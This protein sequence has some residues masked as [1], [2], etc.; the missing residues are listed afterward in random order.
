MYAITKNNF[1]WCYYMEILQYFDEFFNGNYNR[2]LRIFGKNS[3]VKH[4][5][6][7]DSTTARHKKSKRMFIKNN[8]N[9]K[10]A[11]YNR[12]YGGHAYFSD[13][14]D[15]QHKNECV[16]KFNHM[17]FDFDKE[18]VVGSK[19]K[20]ITKG[21]GKENLGITDLE[22]LPL[23]EYMHGMDEIQ[24]QIQDMI[25]YE[26]ILKDSWIES[27]KVYEY[28]KQQGLKAYPCLSMS[29]GVHLRVFFNPIKVK[30][31]NRIIHNLHDN[32]VKQFNLK[33]LDVKVTGKDS[34]PSKSVERLPYTF[35]EKS[36][37][38]VVPFSF[39][40]DRL[41]DVIEKSMK[42]SSKDKLTNVEHFDLSE[43]VNADFHNGILKLDKQIDA[44]IEKENQAKEK[45]LQEKIKNGTINGNY[46][47][48]NALFKDLRILVRFVCGDEN[49]V[50]EHDRYDK[51]KCHFHQDKSPSAIVGMKNYQC[52]SSNCK[53]TK[54]NYF[55]FIRTW[56]GL[57][58]DNEVKQKM[59]ELQQLYDEKIGNV[60]RIGGE[61]VEPEIDA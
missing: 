22:Q 9:T 51:Y 39:E 36:G 53:I 8:I 57:K 16:K 32:L 45:L 29:K 61:D 21:N 41:E 46:T 12:F 44:I 43:H 26:N 19:F 58:S 10:M 5:P 40:T 3:K 11:R 14:L 15:Y 34:N 49:L 18:F 17:F 35:N 7:F 20:N 37:L 50:S 33:T 1:W 54:L 27:Q 56:F 23:K 55:E 47:G 24:E 31:Y 4:A 42:L 52:L 28:F 25:V 6:K 38:R 60:V 59:V 48:A 30:N 13:I 2:D